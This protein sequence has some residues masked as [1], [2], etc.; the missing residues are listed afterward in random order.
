[1]LQPQDIPMEYQNPVQW[2]RH[3]TDSHPAVPTRPLLGK[4]QT[5][6][7]IDSVIEG[8]PLGTFIFRKTA[9]QM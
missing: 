3:R 6:K 4:Q 9:D 1:M 7:L 5:A 2:C 8:F